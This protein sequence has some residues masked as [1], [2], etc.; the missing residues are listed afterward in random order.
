MRYKHHFTE[1][2]YL[3]M[4][5]VSLVSTILLIFFV[6]PGHSV[7][8]FLLNACITLTAFFLMKHF[9]LPNWVLP[10]AVFIG[11]ALTLQSFEYLTILHLALLIGVCIGIMMLLK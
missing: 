11:I 5:V 3:I 8:I 1:K 7:V 2:R 10:I 6:P 9:K 4:F